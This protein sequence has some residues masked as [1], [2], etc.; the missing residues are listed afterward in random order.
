MQWRS[1][2]VVHA[3]TIAILV[4]V[5]APSAHAQAPVGAYLDALGFTMNEVNNHLAVIYNV[6]DQLE[7]AAL[8]VQYMADFENEHAEYPFDTPRSRLDRI[9]RQLAILQNM[10]Q[11]V[12]K[13]VG[14]GGIGLGIYLNV[15]SILNAAALSLGQQHLYI[16]ANNALPP[17]DPAIIDK[18]TIKHMKE[19]NL[20]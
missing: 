19:A 11:V 15:I 12:Q 8:F 20:S 3:A 10:A 1:T 7:D 2:L 18:E 5:I 17:I 9:S 4:G 6:R 16:I 13:N 14:R